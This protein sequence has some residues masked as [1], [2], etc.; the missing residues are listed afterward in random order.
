MA[1]I[2]ARFFSGAFYSIAVVKDDHRRIT[3]GYVDFY[4]VAAQNRKLAGQLLLYVLV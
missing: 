3:T 4:L 2:L 1:P